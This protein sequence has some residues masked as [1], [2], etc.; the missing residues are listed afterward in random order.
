MN[1]KCS[2]GDPIRRLCASAP[3]VEF[4]LFFFSCQGLTLCF[5]YDF[6]CSYALL[7]LIFLS[8]DCL[9]ITGTICDLVSIK[10]ATATRQI[11]HRR[12]P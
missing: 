3:R 5:G 8:P 2:V 9:M 1:F 12:V 4:H 6:G 11:N 10:T 7:I